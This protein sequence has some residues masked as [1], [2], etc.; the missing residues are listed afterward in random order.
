MV[1]TNEP[2]IYFIEELLYPAFEND[3]AQYL[4]KANIMKYMDSNI[5]GVRLED[6]IIVKENGCENMT[7]LAG[8]IRSV[9]EI[10]KIMQQEPENISLLCM[11]CFTE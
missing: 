2:G 11:E 8:A 4:N 6:D 10:E 9:E 5:G 3:F 1:I 7:I